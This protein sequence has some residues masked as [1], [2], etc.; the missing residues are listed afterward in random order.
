MKQF[1]GD[2][3]VGER[4]A[5][6][7]NDTWAVVLAGG[8]G[9]RLRALTT[10]VAGRAVPKQYCSLDGGQSLLQEALLRAEAVAP[11]KRICTIV[12]AQHE[13]WWKEQLA[14]LPQD[15]IIVQPRNRGTA[16]GILLP[17]L[18]I[19]ER[20]PAARIVL[21]PSDHH[22]RDEAELAHSL[23]AAVAPAQASWA[24]IV[25]LG[26]VPRSADPELGYIVPCGASGSQHRG[27]A[28][29][30][31]KPTAAQAR[32]L[33][34]QGA[35]W[36]AFI[37]AADGHALL[38]LFERRCPDVVS[39]MQRVLRDPANALGGERETSEAWV[40]LYDGL[41]EL[42]FSCS[43]LQGQ[44]QHLRVLP[45]PECGWS[46]LGTPERVSEVLKSRAVSRR[47]LDSSI[48]PGGLVNLAEQHQR[49]R[50]TRACA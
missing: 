42:D 34:Q 38:K 5:S 7:A 39:E 26:L 6:M 2:E 18:F 11:P 19:L 16:F 1:P 41:R 3:T 28:R 20:D 13:P 48:P 45:V 47:R 36:N 33:I 9:R 27:V 25:L 4:L 32:E 37:I 29:F 35:L 46:D 43:I 40:E 17:L 8:D 14:S 10:T 12:A 15:N 31:E 30:V 44:E 21:L 24:E 23:R 50:T 22:V 49:M